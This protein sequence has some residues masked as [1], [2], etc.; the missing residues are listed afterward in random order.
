MKIPESLRS[1][2]ARPAV[3]TE[4]LLALCA[5]FILLAGNGPFW[6]AALAN[7]AWTEPGTWLFAGA[8][9]VAL[10]AF[11]L[12]FTALFA[13]RYTVRP[14][15]AVLLIVTAG[16][17]YYMERYAIYLDRAM[18]R[19]VMA[20]N[21]K[22]ASELLGW[23][24][25]VHLLIFGLLPAALLWWPRLKQRPPLRALA[26]RVGWVAASLAI[27]VG[28]LLLVF[29]DFASLMRNHREVRHLITPGNIV[30]SLAGNAWGRAKRPP[31]QARLVVAADAKPGPAKAR[32]TLFVLVVG[33][34]ARAQ[35][36][37]LNGYARVT[38]PELARR[39]VINF[40]DATACGTSTEVSLPCM[41][42]PF[43][44][45]HYNEE[46]I[47]THESVLQVL[48]RA[49]VKVLWRDNQSGCKGV[50][51]GLPQEQLDHAA[52]PSLCADGQ[53]LDEI[54]LH[55]M[56][57]VLRDRQGN[58]LVVMHQLGSHGPAYF[59]RY[60]P[61]FKKFTPAC[62][63]DDLRHCSPE[64]IVNAYDNSILYTD[65]FLGKLIDFLA[66]AQQTHDT[67]MLYVSDHGESLGEGGLYLHGMP[68]AIAP[69]V[70]THVPFVLWLSPAFRDSQGID[71]QCLRNRA[72]RQP[73]SHDFLFHSL[74]GI[75]GV[76]TSAYE[77]PLDLFAACRGAAA[78]LIPAET[79]R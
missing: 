36:F 54:L 77:R 59:K 51:D 27:G 12:A 40:P 74:L 79:R 14:L 65:F 6:R 71:V 3:H 35:N 23:G 33:E 19:N 11:Y 18:L 70:Q 76:Q 1:W 34:T 66:A 16:A 57:Q 78:A 64:E 7:R 75:F 68:W 20:T 48:A 72:L 49:G 53:C 56:D 44:R 22:E 47:V 61:A 41:F 10:S 67:A 43:G 58:L 24:L 42:S 9:F 37:S 31:G 2:P 21:Y 29:A 32:P 38:N 55:G 15:L 62:E 17:A 39:G 5:A 30:A 63:T 73:V 26:V 25:G 28:S 8:V 52:V 46:A 13:S 45:A 60:P 69:D 4:T 50:C